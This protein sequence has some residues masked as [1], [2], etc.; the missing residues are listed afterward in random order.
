M[1]TLLE[2]VCC[3]REWSDWSE[4]VA[5]VIAGEIYTA[6]R[7]T[8]TT[9]NDRAHKGRTVVSFSRDDVKQRESAFLRF[10]RL[11]VI[12]RSYYGPRH[13][14]RR[15]SLSDSKLETPIIAPKDDDG[16]DYETRERTTTLRET[17]PSAL[18]RTLGRERRRRNAA[19]LLPHRRSK[20]RNAR[21]RGGSL[22]DCG[23]HYC[24]AYI[25]VRVFL[26]EKSARQMI[27]FVPRTPVFLSSSI[28]P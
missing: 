1:L 9:T 7:D 24:I 22:G 20:S 12:T 11:F 28:K 6:R 13:R 15:P 14:R 27:V 3:C 16:D 4:G 17:N 10:L 2:E 5:S 8:R 23:L 19:H 26:Q 25:A 18:R 21:E